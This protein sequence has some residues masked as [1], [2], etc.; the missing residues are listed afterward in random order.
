[1]HH[2]KLLDDSVLRSVAIAYSKLLSEEAPEHKGHDSDA[3]PADFQTPIAAKATEDD[4]EEAKKKSDAAKEGPAAAEAGPEVTG[5][6]GE[7]AFKDEHDDNTEVA[8]LPGEKPVKEEIGVAPGKY[9][10]WKVLGQFQTPDG[11]T[12]SITHTVKRARDKEQAARLAAKS[13]KKYG[14]D[15]Y[16]PIRTTPH[17]VAEASGHE[18]TLAAQATAEAGRNPSKANHLKAVEA[19]K[20]AQGFFK[21]RAAE[22]HLNMAINHAKQ[23]SEMKESV[24]KEGADNTIDEAYSAETARS[25]QSAASASKR[26]DESGS[27][28]HHEIAMYRHKKVMERLIGRALKH[29]SNPYEKHR[30]AYT[31][32]HDVVHAHMVA[33]NESVSVVKE[34]EEEKYNRYDRGAMGRQYRADHDSNSSYTPSGKASAST[35]SSKAF[36]ASSVAGESRKPE[37]HAAAHAAHKQAAAAYLAAG[38]KSR[39]QVHSNTAATHAA[40]SG[41]LVKDQA[42]ESVEVTS[43]AITARRE[44]ISAVTFAA[45]DTDKA[46]QTADAL[47]MQ[48]K[49]ATTS[50]T[51][52]AASAAADLKPTANNQT[53][54]V[55]AHVIAKN[56]NQDYLTHLLNTDHDHPDTDIIQHRVRHHDELSRPASTQAQINKEST[57]MTDN[58]TIKTVA[59][60]YRAMNTPAT[61]ISAEATSA[62]PVFEEMESVLQNEAAYIEEA[63]K[64]AAANL[65]EKPKNPH[66][67]NSAL[68]HSHEANHLTGVA[69]HFSK[70]AN[71][72]DKDSDHKR[73]MHAHDNASFSHV[74]AYHTHLQGTDKGDHINKERGAKGVTSG[75]S[76]ALARKH[77]RMAEHHIGESSDHMF[78]GDIY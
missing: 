59:E 7:K 10:S 38:D 1:M 39:A 58:K 31:R 32:H 76:A 35:P 60:S 51:A 42:K 61:G 78:R 50:A 15:E 19:H 2:N 65:P 71:K 54:A 36:A 44:P 6:E 9:S 12:A 8:E 53:A 70:I 13:A 29:A 57:T 55:N 77:D 64:K 52:H 45:A 14:R 63:K 18:S 46:A 62:D 67:K 5:G 16:K 17:T 66:S 33:Q 30:A 74:K 3:E 22:Y 4:E 26:A 24:V 28:E 72:S 34:G 75:H 49:A 23:A 11:K 25:M 48:H 43:E 47:D 21:G 56:T 40:K 73:A 69:K 20:N 41:G 37:D 27:P 68:Y